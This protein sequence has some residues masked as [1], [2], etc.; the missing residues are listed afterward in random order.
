M[1]ETTVVIIGAGQ[2]GLAMSW[3]LRQRSIEHVVLERA[4]IANS[5]ANE[6]W[7][8]LRLLTPNWLARLPGAAYNGPDADGYMFASEFAERLRDY[9]SD[10]PVIEGAGVEAV[11]TVANG[12]DVETAG[13]SWSCLAVVVATGASNNPYVPAVASQFPGAAVQLTPTEYRNPAQIVDGPILIVGASASGAQLA[14]ELTR[15]GRDVTLSVGRHR[16]MIRRYRGHDIFWWMDTI[17][18][19]DDVPDSLNLEGERQ[20]PSLQLV[21][22]TDVVDLDLGTLLAKGVRIVGRIES[23]VGTVAQLGTSV[24]LDSRNADVELD[25]VLHRIDRYVEDHGM[26]DECGPV[27]RPRPLPIPEVPDQLDVAGFATVIWATG[28]KPHLPWLERD[29]LDGR[30]GIVH[31]SGVMSRPGMFVTG[32]P[33]GLRRR[34][35]FIDGAGPDAEDLVALVAAHVAQSE[36]PVPTVSR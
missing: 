24:A 27:E 15:S 34:S 18:M 21:G 10:A 6:R 2:A 33:F 30:G 26:C 28:F 31:H 5:W 22:T 20:L 13:G 35:G 11:R 29:L 25:A 9:G 4:S 1:H 19:L 7:D 3:Q 32:M 23:V 8:S 16:R 12:F 14:D 17:G 36:S